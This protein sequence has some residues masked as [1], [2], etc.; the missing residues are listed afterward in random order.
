[1]SLNTE[2][3][4]GTMIEKLSK[5]A[6]SLK[7]RLYFK[8]AYFVPI[9]SGIEELKK[10]NERGI[11]VRILTNSLASNDVIPSHAGY[12]KQLIKSGVEPYELRPDAGGDNVTNKK[13]LTTTNKFGLHTKTMVFDDNTI[14]ISSF[15]LDPCSA[16][17]NTEGGLYIES[18][19]LA[20][21]VV[22]N[23]EKATGSYSILKENLPGSH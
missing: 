15:N 17:I 7:R 11:K 2:C 19:E 3:Q 23:L 8:S 4:R 13:L 16:A 12:R 21:E 22:S 1:M 18:P 9:D 14:F 20:R 10:L 5:R 6:K